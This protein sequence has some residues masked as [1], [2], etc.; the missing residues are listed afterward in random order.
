MPF[1]RVQR[2]PPR[3][4]PQRLRRRRV[5]RARDDVRRGLQA[6]RRVGRRDRGRARRPALRPRADPVPG[7]RDPRARDR[8]PR[9]ARATG[10]RC[11]SAWGW[12]CWRFAVLSLGFRDDGWG[13][14][15]PYRWLYEVLPG[16]QGIRVPGRLN[17]LT[18]LGLALL[19][20]AG[21]ARARA[22]AAAGWP[23][24]RG[25]C[26]WPSCS[27]RAAASA[28]RIP[29]CR[30]SRRA[31]R[32][33]PGAAAAPA[34]RRRRQPPLP[35]V[36]H[37]RLPGHGQRALELHPAPVPRDHGRGDR[38]PRRRVGGAAA[39]PGRAQRGPAPRPPAR[40]RRGRPGPHVPWTAW[41][42]PGR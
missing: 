25:R 14:L 36:V 10:G 34:G 3:V 40:A 26:W 18:S 42:S 41:G 7:P 13:W 19:A 21:A 37:R 39:A 20:A 22:G 11:G 27:S 12:G 24:S 15:F 32:A 28:T 30:P 1:V 16:W 2:R 9:L 23:R 6:R 4:A 29:G 8:R 31:Q 38:V 33:A 35:A 17:T 5:L